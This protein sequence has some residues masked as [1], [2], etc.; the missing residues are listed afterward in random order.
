MIRAGL[1]IDHE[2]FPR[3]KI[4]EV[5]DVPTSDG[6]EALRN[7]KP[8]KFGEKDDKQFIEALNI[9]KGIDLYQKN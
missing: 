9:L 8:T 1:N 2:E 3:A 6:A 5:K 4:K 7:F